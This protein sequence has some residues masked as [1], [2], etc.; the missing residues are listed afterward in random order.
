MN[1]FKELL[2]TDEK[3]SYVSLGIGFLL[4]YIASHIGG[5]YTV[6]QNDYFFNSALIPAVVVLGLP[7]FKNNFGQKMNS[8]PV[9]KDIISNDIPFIIG[10]SIEV[11]AQLLFI[12]GMYHS[13]SFVWVILNYVGILVLLLYKVYSRE[14]EQV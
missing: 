3:T 6:Y 9:I 2:G 4:G 14:K 12:Y 7:Y 5:I 10:V 11:M 1:Q 13:L 8:I